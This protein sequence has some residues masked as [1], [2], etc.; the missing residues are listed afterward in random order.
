MS[1]NQDLNWQRKTKGPI[2]LGSLTF[3]HKQACFTH[4]QYR[5]QQLGEGASGSGMIVFTLLAR[6]WY[7]PYYEPTSLH[8]IHYYPNNQSNHIYPTLVL[9][10]PYRYQETEFIRIGEP[11][12]D[13]EFSQGH[14]IYEPSL[15][16]CN[17]V[18]SFVSLLSNL[19]SICVRYQYQYSTG[20]GSIMSRDYKNNL[21]EIQYNTIQ[22]LS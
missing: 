22:F 14:Q 16:F 8:L 9:T 19:F 5:D 6:S 20:L 18:F 1:R 7:Q 13:S 12:Q 15:H 11:R 3:L 17:Q 10:M 2:L 21:P 4:H